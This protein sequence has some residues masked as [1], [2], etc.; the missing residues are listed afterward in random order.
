[1]TSRRRIVR[2]AVG[3][4][5]LACAL[6]ACGTSADS[7]APQVLSD[8][9]RAQVQRALDAAVAAGTAGVQVVVTEG[10]RD[11]QATAG[12]GDAGTGSGFPADAHVR[13]G[14]N[15][16]AFAATVIMQLVSAGSVQLDAPIERYLPGLVQGE[17]ID[18]NRIT[19][20]NLMQ[21][22][23]GLPEYL[24]LPELDRDYADLL[25]TRFDA[26]ELVRSAVRTMPAHFPPGEKAEYSNTN[27]LILGLLIE[28]VTG[29]TFAAEVATR[30]T[31]PL[32]LG[33]TYIPAPG[34]LGLR[35][36]HPLGYEVVDGKRTDM[37]RYDP[38]FA[39]AAGA[40]VSTG[41]DLNRFFTALLSGSLL[42][43]AQVTE[44]RRDPRPLTNRPAGIDYGLGLALLTVPCDRQVWGH[45]GSIPGF[46]TYDGV[47]A[48]GRAVSVL[49][50]ERPANAAAAAALQSVFDTAICAGP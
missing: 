48:D 16:K 15:T 29:R 10:G 46:R 19:V 36:P 2:T 22:T 50:N 32:G 38:S 27:Y 42:E 4:L 40:L 28:R 47:T 20:R 7:D 31:E 3:A 14:S 21:H 13:A 11:W 45:G 39:G 49:A 41:A 37:T 43:P 6:T 30:I 5:V 26:A 33:G 23:S 8:S 34:E 12:V 25:D 24:E 9:A 1:M 18:G 35:D 44:M 17:G